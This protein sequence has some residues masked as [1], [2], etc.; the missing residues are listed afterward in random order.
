MMA[1]VPLILHIL[2]FQYSFGC[3]RLVMV[4]VNF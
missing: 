1:H 4:V 3:I 2:L